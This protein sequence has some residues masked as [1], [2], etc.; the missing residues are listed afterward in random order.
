MSSMIGLRSA[1]FVFV[2]SVALS[3][4][5]L[6][7]LNHVLSGRKLLAKCQD[8]HVDVVHNLSKSTAAVMDMSTDVVS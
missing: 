1:E 7:C 8:I 5:H 4:Y 6:V 2:E 3:S